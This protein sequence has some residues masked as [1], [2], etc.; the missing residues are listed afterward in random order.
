VTRSLIAIHCAKICHIAW[1][2]EI[3]GPS[4]FDILNVYDIDADARSRLAE[5]AG[6]RVAIHT[7]LVRLTGNKTP[8][9]AIS[10]L[11][12]D[13]MVCAIPHVYLKRHRDFNRFCFILSPDQE[14]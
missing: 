13:S 12:V 11:E 4:C 8:E 10:S 6:L 3:L 9:L 7:N 14:H 5:S 2:T 1:D